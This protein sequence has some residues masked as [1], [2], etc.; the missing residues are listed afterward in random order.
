VRYLMESFEKSALIG[1]VSDV[2]LGE[3]CPE[4]R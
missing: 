3:E 2:K 4:V 1:E